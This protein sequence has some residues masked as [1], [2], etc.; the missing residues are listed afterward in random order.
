MPIDCSQAGLADPR[1]SPGL[2]LKGQGKGHLNL[3]LAGPVSIIFY[4]ASKSKRNIR[5]LK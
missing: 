5:Y 2:D 1:A 4:I 3:A